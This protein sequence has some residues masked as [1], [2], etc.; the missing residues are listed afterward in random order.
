MGIVE[1]I[2]GQW[3]Y[4]TLPANVSIGPGC[5]IERRASFD[6]FRSEQTP[7]LVL[8]GRVRAYTRTEFNVE[9]TG[10]LEIGADTILVGTDDIAVAAGP[11]RRSTAG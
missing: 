11:V 6:R 7:G 5:W 3:D 8:G 1:E 2:T 9:P 4:S 10:V